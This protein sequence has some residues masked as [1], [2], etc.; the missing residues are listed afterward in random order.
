MK[1]RSLIPFLA[2]GAILAQAAVVGTRS[3]DEFIRPPGAKDEKDFLA[4]C[5]KCGR[6][7]EAC[8]YVALH[9][10]TDSAGL[11]AGTPTLDL[12]SQACRLCEDFPCVEA[13]PTGALRDIEEREDVDMGLAVINN[14]LCIAMRGVRCEVCYRVCPLIDEAIT[15]DYRL[16]EEDEMHTVF[17]PLID[18]EK[19]VGCGLCVE[20]CV[21]EEPEVAIKIVRDRDA[22]L[23][24]TR[25]Q[26]KVSSAILPKEQL[27]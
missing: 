15:I 12:R 2:G 18:E 25:R 19:C 8:P 9:V 14:K 10:A 26:E 21:V 20:R 7:I 4:R 16:R 1:L 5:I 17:A 11:A 24:E 6:C 22:A 23:E 27:Y 3:S 13:C